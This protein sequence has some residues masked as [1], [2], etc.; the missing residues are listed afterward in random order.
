[1]TGR[2]ADGSPVYTYDRLPGVP[3]V[4]VL[5]FDGT[6]L[7]AG[8]PASDHDHAHDFL[9]LAYFERGGGALRLGPRTRPIEAGDAYLIAP[10]EVVGAA[11]TTGMHR[12]VGWAMF[13]PS[14]LLGASTL[15]ANLSWRSHP[16]LFPFV[17]GTAQGAQRLT[18]PPGERASWSDHLWALARELGERRESYAD[19]VMAHVTL[20]LIEVSRLAADVVSDLRLNNQPLV[21][22]VFAVIE[23]RYRQPLSLKDVARA[24]H[25]SPG[26]LTTVVGR[27][28]GR[29]VQEWITERRMAEA[30]RLLVETDLQVAEVG[31]QV[32]Y[33]D[34]AYFAR[35]FRRSHHITPLA[36]RRAGRP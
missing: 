11:D 9:V 7:P 2:R 34:S 21:A 15:G 12:A 36:W 33:A 30:R 3:P 35:S 32:G 22:E 23:D 29:T 8:E 28:T 18:V 31:R 26:H 10:G 19:A 27:K 17:R 14:D 5:R 20:L 4:S 1:M 16:L 25:L 13:F 6:E 24:V